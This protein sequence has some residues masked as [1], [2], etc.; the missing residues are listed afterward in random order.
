VAGSTLGYESRMERRDA[1]LIERMKALALE[2]N[3]YGYRR[4]RVLLRRLGK[5]PPVSEV[6]ED[7]E[8]D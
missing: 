8:D 3:R 6:L 2:N 4:V 7:L 5:M 1:P